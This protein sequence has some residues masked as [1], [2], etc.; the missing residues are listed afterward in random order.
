[1]STA[2]RP[3]LIYLD[4]TQPTPDVTEAPPVTDVMEAPQGTAMQMAAH[5]V[6]RRPSRLARWF[7]GL[8]VALIGVVVSTAAWDFVSSLFLRSSVLAWSVTGLISAVLT[9]LLILALYEV[10][11]IARLSR[12]GSLHRDADTVRT[13]QDLGQARVLV[14][15]LVKLY[16]DRKE[17]G[18][19]RERLTEARADILDAA[20][21]ID[22][23]ETELLGPL[24]KMARREV[25]ASARRVAIV[26][27]LVPLTLADVMVALTVNLR[28]IRHIA[29][30]YGG[31]SGLLGSW[32]LTRAVLTHLVATGAVAVSEDILKQI[33]GGSILARL[34]G[35]LGEG[36]VN[37]MLTARVGLAAMEVC[38][39]L[40]F[41]ACHRPSVSGMMKGAL[42]DLI[43]SKE[44]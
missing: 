33:L 20:T 3:V 36:L 42:A 6:A 13:E 39:P 1:M 14:D 2:K 32:R 12:I 21:L 18:W 24:D 38:R 19:S 4:E 44:S 40:P 35:R 29:E 27:A 30:V 34:S 28:M 31:R 23:A 41:S 26:T 37:G 15:Q 10:A 43:S 5:L 16:A 7:W 8:L 25:E 17:T 22:L 11:A 9:I